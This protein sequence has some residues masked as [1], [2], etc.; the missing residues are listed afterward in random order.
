MEQKTVDNSATSTREYNPPPPLRVTKRSAISNPVAMVVHRRL[1]GLGKEYSGG[2]RRMRRMRSRARGQAA[3]APGWEN[4]VV[5]KQPPR[6]TTWTVHRGEGMRRHSY[7]RFE[8]HVDDSRAAIKNQPK[9]F[10]GWHVL[11]TYSQPATALPP[12]VA[13]SPPPNFVRC[14]IPANVD[15]P[16]TD[17]PPATPERGSSGHACHGP[18]GL[19]L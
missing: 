2:C 9:W 7:H 15:E 12:A 16:H 17:V 4:P 3:Q 13:A 6:R 19:G 14:S 5:V 1:R 18:C 11:G 8:K 10:N